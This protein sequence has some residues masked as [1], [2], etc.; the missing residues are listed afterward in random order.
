MDSGVDDFLIFSSFS[1]NFMNYECG[2]PSWKVWAGGRKLDV[3]P[4]ALNKCS[5]NDV[6]DKSV[7][8]YNCYYYYYYYGEG[9]KFPGCK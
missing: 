5:F 1:M 2:P 8:N 6:L 9:N 4:A 7:T 3:R